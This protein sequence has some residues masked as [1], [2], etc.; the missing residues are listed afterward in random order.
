MA[1]GRRLRR[2]AVA[3]RRLAAKAAVA[4]AGGGA[5][6]G[7]GGVQG[8]G[9]AAVVFRVLVVVLVEPVARSTPEALDNFM[10]FSGVGAR[11]TPEALDNFMPLIKTRQRPESGSVPRV[12]RWGP[13]HSRG[14]G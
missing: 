13:Q 3:A 14:V 7:V 9:G 5:G 6:G 4:G 12:R 2:R 10:P 1:S 11:S 8:A